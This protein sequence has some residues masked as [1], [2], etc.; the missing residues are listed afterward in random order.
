MSVTERTPTSKGNFVTYT[1]ALLFI[2]A[3]FLVYLLGE[4]KQQAE[5][6]FNAR[7]SA[8]SGDL[9]RT[10]EQLG[11]AKKDAAAL[12]ADIEALQQQQ[13]QQEQEYERQA[14]ALREKLASAEQTAR[15]QGEQIQSLK[16]GHAKALDLERG[17]AQQEAEALEAAHAQALQAQGERAAQAL[18]KAEGEHRQAMALAREE[19]QQSL[20]Q[21]EEEAQAALNAADEE[22]QKTLDT[23]QAAYAE[24]QQQFEE[25]GGENVALK[26]DIDALNKTMAWLKEGIAQQEQ[27]LREKVETY[28]IALEGGEPERAFRLSQLEVKVH[29]AQE[30][31]QKARYDWAVKEADYGNRLSAAQQLAQGKVEAL[32]A[33]SRSNAEY[34]EQLAALQQEL[35][36][37]QAQAANETEQLQAAHRD[38]VQ[39]LNDRLTE[40]V[41]ALE[42]EKT[43]LQETVLQAQQTEAALQGEIEALQARQAQAETQMAALQ[44]EL[45]DLQG[46]LSGTADR[47]SAAEGKLSQSEEKL[48][49]ASQELADTGA[50]LQDSE[51]QL[52]AV[53]EQMQEAVKQSEL[54]QTEMQGA[55]A[56]L[57]QT[58]QQERTEFETS[59]SALRSVNEKKT[60]QLQGQLKTTA[61]ELAR[62]QDSHKKLEQARATEQEQAKN[63]IAGLE[64]TL[65]ERDAALQQGQAELSATRDQLAQAESDKQAL[66]ARN[67]LQELALREARAG[68]AETSRSLEESRRATRGQR[69]M[70]LDL[71]KQDA[72]LTDRGM[73]LTLGESDLQFTLGK[74]DLSEGENPSLAR[75]T[76]FL[77][78]NPNLQA[79]LVGHT[80]SVGKKESNLVLSRERAEAVKQAL[81]AMG[82][83][84]ARISTEGAGEE[85]PIASNMH[86]DGQSKNRRVEVYL[87]GM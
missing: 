28:R 55:I 11:A 73:Q 39:V 15:Q 22:A 7:L 30:A 81:V 1:L 78:Q 70:Y 52:Q 83:D 66:A 3:L 43:S 50:R 20:R 42:Q 17:K 57:E 25:L 46:H 60:A 53:R 71:F 41:A 75:I 9:A 2:A 34:K 44:Q 58:L 32:N 76:G 23:Q 33:T 27:E 72:R 80:D 29:E 84:E 49:A 38:E 54:K 6:E 14:A 37:T 79:L 67:Q 68:F 85:Q 59:F 12:G 63:A 13:R 65:A 10:E 40:A 74:A 64:K 4:S 24:L 5:A 8:S 87:S 45:A 86:P 16:A 77:Q 18:A 31:L 51:K 26:G 19:A 47:L 21:A 82:I 61:A 62:L 48:V 69:Q 35:S 36:A 56:S